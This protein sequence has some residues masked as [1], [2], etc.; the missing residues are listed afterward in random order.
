[1]TGISDAIVIGSGWA[2]LTC[3][4]HLARAGRSVVLLEQHST[5][6]GLLGHWH[7]EGHTFVRACNEFAS[8]LQRD[9]AE[10]E[11]PVQF[12]TTRSL[13]VSGQ[14]H[15][16]LPPGLPEAWLALRSLSAPW[17]LP[18]VLRE[19]PTVGALLDACGAPPKLAELLGVLAYTAGV[20][21]QY[22]RL[23]DLR[24]MATG[25]Y[26]FGLHRLVKPVGGPQAILDALLQ[27]LADL[28]VQVHTNAQV[29]QVTRAGELAEV[30]SS[31]GIF[32]ARQ[33]A[34]SQPRWDLYPPSA[35]TGLAMGQLLLAVRPGFQFPQGI[36]TVYHL[37]PRI[38]AWMNQLDNGQLPEHFGFSVARHVNL[39][40]DLETLNCFVLFPR[41]LDEPDPQTAAHIQAY[42]L[43]HAEK[44]VPGLLGAI[45]FQHLMPPA[46]FVQRFRLSSAPIPYLPPPGF[47]I[48]DGFDPQT[49]I[50]HLGNSVRP[51]GGHAGAA[52]L[53]GKWAADNILKL[54]PARA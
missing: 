27:R 40:G 4:L 42:V 1:M 44:L 8:G 3:A 19:S 52:A 31:Q 22:M 20:P 41:G 30:H 34:S 13:I 24:D 6:G 37:P 38:R 36:H 15:L 28:G 23:E 29:T 50:H 32:H 16:H 54:L 48:P 46:E 10:L 21:M 14:Q 2:G 25:N 33:V 17:K 35:P 39:P 11:I 18:R 7:L 45:A 49:G 53:S 43:Q 26:R 9:L 47:Q 51:I 12:V 5:P